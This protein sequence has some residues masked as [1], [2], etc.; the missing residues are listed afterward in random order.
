MQDASADN[1]AMTAPEET[2]AELVSASG[3][4]LHQLSIGQQ[5]TW[6][7][8]NSS[9]A[10]RVS[11]CLRCHNPAHFLRFRHINAPA[12]P[13]TDIEINDV[14]Q[15]IIKTRIWHELTMTDGRLMAIYLSGDGLARFFSVLQATLRSL[16]KCNRLTAPL[17]I[18]ST[19]DLKAQ[20]IVVFKSLSLRDMQDE[21]NSM[22]RL[23]QPVQEEESDV[24]DDYDTIQDHD[25]MTLIASSSSD[26][27]Y[28]EPSVE[29]SATSYNGLRTKENKASPSLKDNGHLGRANT[30]APK[31]PPRPPRDPLR[32]EDG[33]SKHNSLPSRPTRDVCRPNCGEPGPWS[34]GRCTL[35]NEPDLFECEVCKALRNDAWQCPGVMCRR[36]LN[37]IDQTVCPE[38][39][40]W[41]CRQCTFVN[42]RSSAMCTCCQT[43]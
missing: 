38:C 20:R 31:P 36:R 13:P 18:F 16:G 21:Y 29:G 42:F 12:E 32:P 19:D 35:H 15:Y 39:G 14:K 24:K 23:P 33:T 11:L 27:S 5:S 4:L 9:L 41:K 17:D 22:Q 43:P 8:V 40:A 6:C 37:C 30:M 28:L 2:D 7:P 3:M 25:Y 10:D 34:C 26:A 1:Y